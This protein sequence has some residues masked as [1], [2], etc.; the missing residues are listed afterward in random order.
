MRELLDLQLAQNK[1]LEAT[2]ERKRK[3]KQLEMQRKE[4]A[5]SGRGV[6]PRTPTYPT[7]TPPTRPVVTDTYDS[8]E[9]EKNRTT[10]YTFSQLHDEMYQR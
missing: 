7:Y 2:E 10:K 4:L 8:Y 1:E 9:A 5:R 3:A 6:T